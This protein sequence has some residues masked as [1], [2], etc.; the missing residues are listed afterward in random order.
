M[1]RIYQNKYGKK[2]PIIKKEKNTAQNFN[3]NT[4]V[5]FRLIQLNLDEL[6]KKITNKKYP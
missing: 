1:K 2:I 3:V 5:K 4:T 6:V